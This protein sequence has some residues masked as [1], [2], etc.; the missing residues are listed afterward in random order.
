MG[1]Y[2]AG[3]VNGWVGDLL[4]ALEVVGR[5]ERLV[6]GWVEQWGGTCLSE[7]WEVAML[8]GKVKGE[9]TR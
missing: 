1:G 8:G 5:V 4:V 7:G 6:P 3:W 2:P 9:L